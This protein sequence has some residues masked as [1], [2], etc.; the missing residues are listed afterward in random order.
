MTTSQWTRALTEKGL[1][2]DQV[3]NQETMQYIPC[4]SEMSSRHNDWQV[5]WKLCRTTGLNSEMISFNFKLLHRLLPV[6]DHLHHLTPATSP[7]CTMCSNS[8][9]ETLQHALLSCSYN[10]GTGQVLVNTLQKILPAL[11]PEKI[12]FLQFPD[13]TESQEMSLVFLTS[14]MLLEVW[15]RRTKKIKISLF[16]IRSTLEAKVSLLRETRHKNLHETLKRFDGNYVN[17]VC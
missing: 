4:S 16:D 2:M 17:T 7:T 9:P 14:S 1:T 6:K 12:L 8:C 5:S 10:G 13:V 3:P 15:N 11:T